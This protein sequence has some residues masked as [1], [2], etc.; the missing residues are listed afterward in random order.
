[1][2]AIT[3]ST[4]QTKDE[5][6]ANTGA[7]S[8]NSKQ[9]ATASA[10]SVA[11]DQLDSD[12]E[13]VSKRLHTKKNNKHS[14]ESREEARLR[15]ERKQ[16]YQIQE[17]KRRRREDVTCVQGRR[18]KELKDGKTPRQQKVERL[19]RERKLIHDEYAHASMKKKKQK[20]KKKHNI[21]LP[22]QKK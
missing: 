4:K 17:Q 19:R 9:Q 22:S 21:P 11:T 16:L 8:T 2:Q 18:S 5:A 10:Q 6:A 12:D 1:M 3:M 13:D 7:D 15:A 14:R 20:K